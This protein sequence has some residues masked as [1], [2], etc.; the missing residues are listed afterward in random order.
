MIIIDVIMNISG[1]KKM[2]MLVFVAFI[3]IHKQLVRV[4]RR[5]L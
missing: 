2:R 4:M 1:W 5:A 3:S